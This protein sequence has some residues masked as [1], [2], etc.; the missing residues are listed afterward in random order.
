MFTIKHVTRTSDLHGSPNNISLYEGKFP[1]LAPQP[2]GE[3]QEGGHPKMVLYF[4]TE[5]ETVCSIDSG[6]VYVMNA[7][8]KTVETFYLKGS[9]SL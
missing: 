5:D 2:N 6:K 4:D 8:G 1:R 7:A 9:E 3:A